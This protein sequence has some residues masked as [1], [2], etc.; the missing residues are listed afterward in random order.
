MKL[1]SAALR[2]IPDDHFRS[3]KFIERTPPGGGRLTKFVTYED[4]LLLVMALGGKQAT[5]LQTQF[6]KTLQRQSAASNVR[7]STSKAKC[8]LMGFDTL[9]RISGMLFARERGI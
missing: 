3:T 2:A 6:A 8:F 9:A 4:A 1:P 7:V 5:L